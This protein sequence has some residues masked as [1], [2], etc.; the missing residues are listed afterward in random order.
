VAEGRWGA[1][2]IA[3]MV[4]RVL[5]HT[6]QEHDPLPTHGGHK[7]PYTTHL[8]PYEYCHQLLYLST[9]G[10]VSIPLG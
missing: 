4:A 7:G 5:S 8:H 3:F 10:S 9:N 2:F 6:L 1:A